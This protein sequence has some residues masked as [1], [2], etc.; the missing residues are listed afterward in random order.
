MCTLS[1]GDENS[2]HHH[3]DI[4]YSAI[5]APFYRYRGV[6]GT[7]NMPSDEIAGVEDMYG[8]KIG[9]NGSLSSIVFNIQLDLYVVDV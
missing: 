2:S 1:L 3:F 9:K 4:V 7:F 5:M 6:F 8:K